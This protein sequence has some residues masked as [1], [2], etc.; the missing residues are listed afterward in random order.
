MSNKHAFIIM[1]D[2]PGVVVPSVLRTFDRKQSMD[3]RIP[4]MTI[5]FK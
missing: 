3:K 2:N 1:T 4:E 5:N